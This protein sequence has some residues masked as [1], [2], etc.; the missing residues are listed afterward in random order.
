MDGGQVIWCL[1]AWSMC[2]VLELFF[3]VLWIM[4]GGVSGS[5]F[6]ACV[7][8]QNY[9]RCPGKRVAESVLFLSGRYC[10]HLLIPRLSKRDTNFL[11]LEENGLGK[12]TRYLSSS[13]IS[14]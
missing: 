13:H 6:C 2:V 1:V 3:L 10:A 11:F 9:T 14:S 4:L 5:C 12:I 8:V 7:V